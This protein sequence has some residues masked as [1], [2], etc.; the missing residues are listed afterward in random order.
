M[1]T[2][3]GNQHNI[4]VACRDVLDRFFAKYPNLPLQKS[5][6]TAL[7][8]LVA[9]G[10]PLLGKPEGWTA[11]LVYALANHGRIPVGLP[12]L[13]NSEVEAYFGVSMSTI[14]KRAAQIEKNLT[15]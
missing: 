11:G 5:T 3:A 13:L 4:E 9:S 8:F 7:R 12:G 14:R 10:E 15:I 6:M 2:N 1:K